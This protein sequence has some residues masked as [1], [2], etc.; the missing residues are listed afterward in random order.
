[1]DIATSLL[2]ISK[3]LLCRC[4]SIIFIRS[5]TSTSLLRILIAS[6]S[7]L[8]LEFRIYLQIL[9][10]LFVSSWSISLITTTTSVF[11]LFVFLF[12]TAT[13]VH[14]LTASIPLFLAL[15]LYILSN[16]SSSPNNILHLLLK[17][18]L[19]I[20]SSLKPQLPL[21]LVS[22]NKRCRS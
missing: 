16:L 15:F 9:V 7:L 18:L 20:L 8:L 22:I 1:M 11:E 5:R 13:N 21:K 12:S 19:I 6:S 4:I 14:N 2:L 17:Y 10:T 3:Q